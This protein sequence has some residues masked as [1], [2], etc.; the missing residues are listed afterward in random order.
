MVA[1]LDFSYGGNYLN[2]NKVFT[3]ITYGARIL[4][5]LLIVEGD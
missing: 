2:I 1:L 3:E 4:A 5:P